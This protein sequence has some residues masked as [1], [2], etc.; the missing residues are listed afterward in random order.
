MYA[1]RRSQPRFNCFALTIGIT[2]ALSPYSG[3]AE[4]SPQTT[5]V[6]KW[7]LG[8]SEN[9]R[10]WTRISQESSRSVASNCEELR[11]QVRIRW[12]GNGSSVNWLPKCELVL[13]PTALEYQRALGLPGAATSG[14]SSITLD[15]G[16]V[17]SRRIDL[18]TDVEDWK[19]AQLP[20]EIT[21]IVMADRF[22][23]HRIRCWADE[24]M[25]IVAEPAQKR[26]ARYQAYRQ[27]HQRGIEYSLRQLLH[28]ERCAGP[29]WSDAFYGQSC[30]LVEMLLSRGTPEQLLDFL[31]RVVDEG[32][33]RALQ[34]AYRI[35]GIQGL[36]QLIF[37]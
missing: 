37:R 4:P 22:S 33:D 30:L 12:F 1:S 29:E 3:I 8:E 27:S 28:A 2:I 15:G 9:F 14:C 34:S 20:H 25:A 31:D 36:E 11:S 19:T 7:F 26:A 23:T 13:H 16:R 6:Q 17:V 5:R 24:G 32:Y 10:V 18:R 35:Q 21:H